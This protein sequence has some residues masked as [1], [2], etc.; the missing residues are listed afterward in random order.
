MKSMSSTT[1]ARRFAKI[2]DHQKREAAGKRL[3]ETETVPGYLP[4][5]PGVTTTTHGKIPG[6]VC[7][8]GMMLALGRVARVAAPTMIS[9]EQQA[10]KSSSDITGTVE[11]C[12]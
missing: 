9:T 7:D 3:F 4:R 12:S 11:A 10:I 6:G 2:N 5:R 8:D 1:R